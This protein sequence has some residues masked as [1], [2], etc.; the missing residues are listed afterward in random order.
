MA[1]PLLRGIDHVFFDVD[2]LDRTGGMRLTSTN[3]GATC[4]ALPTL[5]PA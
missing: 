3:P 1:S 2:D 5:L 4:R